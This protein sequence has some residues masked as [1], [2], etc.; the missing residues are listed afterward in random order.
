MQNLRVAAVAAGNA[1]ARI[2]FSTVNTMVVLAHST[3]TWCRGYSISRGST[4]RLVHRFMVKKGALSLMLKKGALS[5]QHDLTNQYFTAKI[6]LN[7][8]HYL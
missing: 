2:R 5:L 7:K 4:A 8:V 1:T 3:Q 6:V